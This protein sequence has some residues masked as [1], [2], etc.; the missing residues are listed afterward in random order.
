MLV[1]SGTYAINGQEFIVLSDKVNGSI[2][3]DFVTYTWAYHNDILSLRLKGD[4]NPPE[5]FRNLSKKTETRHLEP[6]LSMDA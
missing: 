6:M 2:N 3:P 1:A 5:C 4:N